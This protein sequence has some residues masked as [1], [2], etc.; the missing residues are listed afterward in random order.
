MSFLV[1]AQ[2]DGIVGRVQIESDHVIDLVFGLG[3]GAELEGFDPVGLERMS[4]PDAMHR[5]V[6]QIELLGQIPRLVF[7]AS[8]SAATY[9]FEKRR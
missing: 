8:S 4:F 6:R 3:V 9:R 5:A 7:Q 1:H 2:D